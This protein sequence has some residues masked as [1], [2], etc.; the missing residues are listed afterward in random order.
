[1]KV[2]FAFLGSI[3]V[4]TWACRH[5]ESGNSVK[6]FSGTEPSEYLSTNF[7]CQESPGKS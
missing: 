5:T 3:S 6:A 2:I 1:M 7:E 4:L